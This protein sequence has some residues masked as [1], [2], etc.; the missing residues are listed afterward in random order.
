MTFERALGSPASLRD[1]LEA[2][3][4]LGACLLGALRA[5]LLNIDERSVLDVAAQP[6]RHQPLRQTQRLLALPARQPARPLEIAEGEVGTLTRLL[7]SDAVGAQAFLDHRAG[8]RLEAHLAAARHH[9]R[10]QPTEEIGD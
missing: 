2:G 1:L 9:G 10:Q 6:R 3:E 8:Q 4:H 5:V 7:R